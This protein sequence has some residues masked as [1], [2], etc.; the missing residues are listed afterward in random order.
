MPWYVSGS[1]VCWEA[2]QLRTEASWR[3]AHGRES[4]SWSQP[5]LWHMNEK[6]MYVLQVT[7][8]WNLFL[9]TPELAKVHPLPSG[10]P[11]YPFRFPQNCDAEWTL[12]TSQCCSIPGF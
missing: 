1:P 12:H 5:P 6:Q 4:S 2:P 3:K 11:R 8:D 9:M 7:K 10:A